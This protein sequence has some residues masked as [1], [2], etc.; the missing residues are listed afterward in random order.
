MKI[1]HTADWH[2]GKIVH[3]VSMLDEQR[4][5]L[6]QFI[7]MIQ[8]EKPDLVIIAGD[9]YDR[10][11]PPPE[12][13]SLL[14]EFLEEVVLTLHIPIIAIAGNHDSP[15]RLQF[16]SK[17]MEEKGF[18]ITGQ[19][20]KNIEP[21][22]LHDNDGPVHFYAI[23]YVDPSIVRYL[24]EDESI[25]T[26]DDAFKNIVER[27]NETLNHHV[28]NVFI[29]HA[30]ITP[31]GEKKEN[32]SDSE[33][34][35]SVGGIEY[36]NAAH[37]EIFDYVALGHLHKAHSVKENKI[38]YSGSPLKYS[39]SEEHHKKGFYNVDLQKDGSITIE[40]RL[41]VPK[42]DMRT[43]EGTIEEILQMESSEDFVFVKLLN[44]SPVLSPMEKVRTVFPNTLHLERSFDHFAPTEEKMARIEK[45]QQS[46]I[47]IFKG[48]YEEVKGFP[49][50][51]DT[52]EVFQEIIDELLSDESVDY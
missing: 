6:R 22:I 8:K 47:E 48:F 21:I 12:A 50:E 34:M 14:N 29:G 44:R 32:T 43:I 28:R 46:D 9:L 52:L 42:R 35:L 17:L 7:D 23:P 5:I 18:Y 11:I 16:G 30:F 26:F 3:G 15:S 19:L 20:E 31:Q 24:Y 45:N 1:F 10:A 36:V 49:P 33:R 40:Q 25:H 2:L 27:I 51:E 13:V 37:F 4:Y 39:I 38:R 41:L